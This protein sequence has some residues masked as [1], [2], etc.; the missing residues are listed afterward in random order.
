[1]N[2][3]YSDLGHCFIFTNKKMRNFPYEEAVKTK[4]DQVWLL[5]ELFAYEGPLNFVKLN[6]QGFAVVLSDFPLRKP[7]SFS[8]SYINH[9]ENGKFRSTVPLWRLAKIENKINIKNYFK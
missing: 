6:K 2:I 5:N 1:M 8:N 4:D 7:E 9:K 3:D